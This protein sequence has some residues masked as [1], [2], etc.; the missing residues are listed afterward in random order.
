MKAKSLLLTF[1]TFYL[2]AWE[3]QT[4][5]A[6]IVLLFSAAC[7]RVGALFW[8]CFWFTKVS[9]D[10]AKDRA[11]QYQIVYFFQPFVILDDSSKKRHSCPSSILLWKTHFALL[12][13]FVQFQLGF[14]TF[15]C[16]FVVSLGQ[17]P[18]TWYRLRWLRERHL[19][20]D[21]PPFRQCEWP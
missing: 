12:L 20:L 5:P 2:V 13:A 7:S 11:T 21:H 16:P 15:S 19:Q 8:Y 18:P 9:Q 6:S 4:R 3:C 17:S 14:P 10:A 1:I